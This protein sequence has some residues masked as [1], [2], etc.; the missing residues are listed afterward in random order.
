MRQLSTATREQVITSLMGGNSICTSSE[1]VGVSRNAIAKLVV[2]LGVACSQHQDGAF[3]E[4]KCKSLQA[5]IIGPFPSSTDAPACALTA[6]DPETKVVPSF[7]IFNYDQLLA[8]SLERHFLSYLSSRFAIRPENSALAGFP[9]TF[10]A[11]GIFSSTVGT[12]VLQCKGT[13]PELNMEPQ[14]Q[15]RTAETLI[16]LSGAGLSEEGRYRE[17]NIEARTEDRTAKPFIL[18]FGAGLSVGCS[19]TLHAQTKLTKRRALFE[20]T[21]MYFTYY[22]FVRICPDFHLTPAMAA[23][24]AKRQWSVSDLIALLDKGRSTTNNTVTCP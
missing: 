21:A 9:E 5:R 7:C 2:D 20:A 8:N 13:Q 10:D 4:L 15:D 19:S 1:V 23:G 18:L 11:D 3:R 12:F 6:I 16:L 24:I 17:S 22:N 14:T